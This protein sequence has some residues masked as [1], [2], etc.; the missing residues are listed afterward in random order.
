LLK[1]LAACLIGAAFAVP[2]LAQPYP[3][4]PIRMIIGNPAGEAIGERMTAQLGQPIVVDNRPGAASMI[5]LDGVIQSAPDGYTVGTLT[6]PTI[7]SGILNGRTWNPDAELTALGLNYQQGVLITLNPTVPL[8]KDVKGPADIVRVVK[9]NPGKIN[10]GSIGVGSTGHLIGELMKDRAGLNWVHVPFKGGVPLVQEIVAGREPI[11]SISGTFADAERNP[12]RMIV[13]ATTGAKPV[14]GVQPL[15]SVFPG[16]IATTWGGL[17]GPGKLPA[18]IVQR[19]AAAYKSAWDTPEI[20]EK[21][22][23]ILTQEYLGPAEMQKLI[24]DAVALWGKVIKDNN[25]KP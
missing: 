5:G 16:L 24:H 6:S 4:K 3:N 21:S 8:L 10:F 14:Q 15:A 11:I 22:G 12:G 13:V 7:I 1:K 25:I 18:P 17:V 20:Q 2:A 23:R 9:A 19:L